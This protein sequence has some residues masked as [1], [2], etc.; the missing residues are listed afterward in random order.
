MSNFQV[1]CLCLSFHLIC[2][3]GALMLIINT[4][5]NHT[6]L[7]VS[8]AVILIISYLYIQLRY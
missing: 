2:S 5:D 6:V 7:Y 4:S 3:T 8:H 1:L